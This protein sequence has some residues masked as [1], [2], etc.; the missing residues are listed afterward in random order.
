MV[1][2][3]PRYKDDADLQKKRDLIQKVCDDGLKEET[4]VVAE[5]FAIDQAAR[6]RAERE[7][8]EMA[9]SNS[10]LMEAREKSE[11]LWKRLSELD[12]RAAH[13]GYWVITR[14]T[15]LEGLPGLKRL[16]DVRE[17]AHP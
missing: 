16:A 7:L 3:G 11:I 8:L 5:K 9:G 17:R 13:A 2:I 15:D 6:T 14:G 1:W 10:L 12:D 4:T